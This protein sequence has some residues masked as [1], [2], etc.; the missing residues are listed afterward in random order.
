MQFGG[1]ETKFKSF[2]FVQESSLV[3]QYASGGNKK[4][5]AGEYIFLGGLFVLPVLL[6][7][8]TWRR[9]VAAE[10]P[11]SGPLQ[12]KTGIAFV[13]I[14]VV[15]WIGT[16]NLMIAANH[17]HRP[18]TFLDSLPVPAVAFVGVLLSVGGIL[19]SRLR[20]N[21]AGNSLRVRKAM[22]LASGIMLVFWR[23]I[24]SNPH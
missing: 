11:I 3:N 17:V 24:L 18:N 1:T 21:A 22:G 6:V 13:S 5:T 4:T 19:S 23:F 20:R 15:I 2:A 8:R 16:I 10:Q 12:A 9:Y 14:S 7:L